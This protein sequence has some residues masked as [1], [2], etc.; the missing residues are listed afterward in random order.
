MLRTTFKAALAGAILSLAF[1][2]GT[3]QAAPVSPDAARSV[4]SQSASEATPVHWRRHHARWHIT[5]RT[6][7][8]GIAGTGI[9]AI[10][11]TCAAVAIGAAGS[12]G[13]AIATGKRQK[14]KVL[15]GS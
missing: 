3:A 15:A 11:A 10:A 4:A 5:G 6:G 14:Y 13:A 2:A 7:I 9:T 12:S 8:I 1:A